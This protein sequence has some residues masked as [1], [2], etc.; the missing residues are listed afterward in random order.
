M[1]VERTLLSA[2]FDVVLDL[3]LKERLPQA[4]PWKSGASAACPERSRMGSVK[5]P[6]GHSTL[7][8]NS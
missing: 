3:E 2:A 6:G 1:L 7:M 8:T 4:V 5:P